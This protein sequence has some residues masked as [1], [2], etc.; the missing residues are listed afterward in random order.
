MKGFR[1]I[2]GLLCRQHFLFGMSGMTGVSPNKVAS[3]ALSVSTPFSVGSRYKSKVKV[4]SVEKNVF[5][6]QSY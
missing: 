5:R 2:V 1:P 3:Q 4:K 6:P